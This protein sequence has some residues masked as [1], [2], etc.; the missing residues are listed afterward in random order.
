V[1]FGVALAHDSLPRQLMC[2]R[3]HW[4]SASCQAEAVRVPEPDSYLLVIER[5]RRAV[6]G[7]AQ[8][9]SRRVLPCTGIGID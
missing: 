7:R 6:F 3:G 5:W 8:L 4:V 2:T 1:T 9:L